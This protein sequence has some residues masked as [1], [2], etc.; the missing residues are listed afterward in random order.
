MIGILDYGMGNLGSV[1]NACAFLGLDACIVAR[2]EE[3]DDCS[4]VILPGVGAFGDCMKHLV[5]HGFVEPVR[6]WIRADRPFLGICLGLQVLFEGSEE[7]PGVPGLGLLPGRVVRFRVNQELKVPQIGWNRV[8]QS[9]QDCPLFAEVADL[10]F[11]YF[12]HS[13]YV[14]TPDRSAIVGVTDYGVDYTSAVWRGR[15]MAV[16]F[17]PE[18]SQALGLKLLQNFQAMVTNPSQTAPAQP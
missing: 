15:M 17:H 1:S 9:R 5:D 13:Y 4:A 11:F 18:K 6:D 16:Q 14:D 3:M 8:R 12:V 10:S 7:S 2:P